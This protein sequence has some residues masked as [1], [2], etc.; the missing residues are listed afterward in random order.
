MLDG[1]F[2]NAKESANFIGCSREWFYTLKEKYKL[3]PAARVANMW[4]YSR[5]DLKR[6]KKEMANV[7]K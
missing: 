5:Q 7:G 2:L 4:L 1:K 3:E 6:I